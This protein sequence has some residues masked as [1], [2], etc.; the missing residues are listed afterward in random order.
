MTLDE[1]YLGKE[2]VIKE[3]SYLSTKD[4]IDSFVQRMKK[5]TDDF[6]IIAKAPDQIVDK[7]ITYN[8]VT[9]EARLSKNLIDNRYAQTIG[10]SYS[11]DGKKPLYKLYRCYTDMTTNNLIVLDEGDIATGVIEQLMP[12]S[13]DLDSLLSRTD[14]FK[15]KLDAMKKASCQSDIYQLFGKYLHKSFNCSYNNGQQQVRIS[16]DLVS[17]AY[18]G[19]FLDSTSL[20][21]LKPN[22]AINLLDIY[23]GF[24]QFTCLPKDA[25]NRFEKTAIIKELIL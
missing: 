7:A 11:L 9:I 23:L 3:K 4:Y 22:Q 2:T 16:S 17:S 24:N 18:K 10:L 20:S 25:L 15:V 12:L 13:Y 19:L 14:S 6:L 21:Y 5:L 8:R 1:L